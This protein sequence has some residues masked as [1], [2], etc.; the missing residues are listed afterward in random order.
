VKGLVIL[1]L[2]CSN[3]Y[4]Q[5][6]NIPLDASWNFRKVGD[7]EWLTATVPGTVHTDLLNNRRITDPFYESNE[8]LVQWIEDADWEYKTKFNCS[9]QLLARQNIELIFEGLDTYAQVFLNDALILS[10]DNMFRTWRADCKS[11]LRKG[12]NELR[13]VFQS[14]V[15]EGKEAAKQ[16]HYTLP[17]DEKVFTRKAQYQ[18]GW[19]WGPRLVTCGVWRPVSLSIWDEVKIEDV[20]SIQRKLSDSIAEI[21]F[22]FDVDCSVEGDYVFSVSVDSLNKAEESFYLHQGRQKV[23]VNIQIENPERWWPNGMAEAHLTYFNCTVAKNHSVIDSKKVVTGLR[24]VELV[25]EKD[26]I[27][28]SFF[29]KVNGMPVFMKGANWIPADNFL[30]RVTKE[31]YRALITK[32]KQANINML[33]V[34]GGGV[35]EDDYFYTLCDSLGILVWQ[36]FMFACAMYPGDTAFTNNAINEAQE[37]IQRLRNHPCIALWCGNNEIDEGWKNWG[38]QKQYNYIHSDSIKIWSDYKNLFENI[39]PVV[40]KENDSRNYISTS[41]M[42]GWGRKESLAE[43]DCHYWGV[44]WGMEP[45]AMYEKKIGRFMSEYGFQGMP[46]LSTFKKF[47][48]DDKLT[49]KSEAV[50]NHQKHKT[51]YETI[52][53]YLE[54]D[55]RQPK[56]FESY[57]YVSQLLQAEGMKIAIEAHRRAKP[58]CMGTLYWQLNDCWP[59]TSWSSIDYYGNEKALYYTVK[60]SFDKYSISAENKNDSIYFTAV[61]DELKNMNAGYSIS[62]KDF[63]GAVLWNKEGSCMLTNKESVIVFKTSVADLLKNRIQGNIFLK[64]ELEADKKPVVENIFYFGLPKDLSLQKQPIDFAIDSVSVNQFTLT[65]SAPSLAKNVFVDFGD[66]KVSLSDNF[67]DVLPGEGKVIAIST[68]VKLMELKRSIRVKSLVDTY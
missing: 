13:I 35:Y 14:S 27:G 40:V 19:D 20:Q 43:G 2:L 42:H 24:T 41:P 7:K 30:H 26:S 9:Q 67:F 55:Y 62:L 45:F 36:D 63:N 48:S 6:V 34:W 59:V 28:K 50:K 47:C 57:I 38:W 49:L 54:R 39:L 33:R 66:L 18:Y 37:N 53:T 15:R 3:L 23:I 52:Q 21:D 68:K 31:K 12:D 17:G 1:F 51:G 10:A 22:I 25:Q 11:Y 64:M 29:F 4:S 5:T 16:L 65:V 32:A 60:K 58:Y 56:D 44:W 46:E 8:K 61:S